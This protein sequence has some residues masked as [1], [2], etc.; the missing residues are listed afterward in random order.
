MYIYVYY[1]GKYSMSNEFCY[2]PRDSSVSNFAQLFFLKIQILFRKEFLWKL[3][4]EISFNDCIIIMNMM[5]RAIQEEI[6]I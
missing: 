3:Q 1:E 4:G 6:Q 2:H 5:I